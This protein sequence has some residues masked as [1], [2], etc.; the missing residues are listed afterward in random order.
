MSNFKAGQCVRISNSNPYY[1]E[2]GTFSK[3]HNVRYASYHIL[4]DKDIERGYYFGGT[5]DLYSSSFDLKYCEHAAPEW[6][7]YYRY[8]CSSLKGKSIQPVSAA[9]FESV[10]NDDDLLLNSLTTY[11]IF[12]GV[13][14][15]VVGWLKENMLYFSGMNGEY[16]KAKTYITEEGYRIGWGVELSKNNKRVMNN[17][18]R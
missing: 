8:R 4:T 16:Y 9:K 18:I 7:Q 12:K 5:S 15:K 17:A 11:I 13:K 6:A 10:Y 3:N 2:K 1:A 14:T